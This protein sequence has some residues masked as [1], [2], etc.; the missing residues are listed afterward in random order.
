PATR[1]EIRQPMGVE[2]VA[3]AMP[4]RDLSDL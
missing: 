1:E 3:E 2:P 4:H